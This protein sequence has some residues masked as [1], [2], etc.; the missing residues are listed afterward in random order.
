MNNCKIVNFVFNGKD[1]EIAIYKK[2]I[3]SLRLKIN[4]NGEISVNIPKLYPYEKAI[5]FINEKTKWIEKHLNSIQVKKDKNC[6][7]NSGSIIYIWGIPRKIVIVND[8]HEDI[9]LEDDCIIF[10]V[11]NT[12][13]E[14]IKKKFHKWAKSYYYGHV[15]DMF[16][17]V[18]KNIFAKLKINKPQL[19]IRPMIS[20]WGNC[21]YGKEVI[22]LNYYLFKAPIE[23][24]E[25]VILHELAHMIYHDHGA[26][27]KA[28]LTKHMPDWK[29][30]KKRL[31]NY[32]LCF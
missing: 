13:P 8:L 24:V 5:N 18:Y 17:I 30:R 31:N 22:T 9:D 19:I 2:S 1:H 21:K 3:R 7:F 16:E 32:S 15:L 29:A 10:R 4:Q 27:F 26:N 14:Y 12:Q 6:D 25:Y 20:M 11:K 28:F 23:C